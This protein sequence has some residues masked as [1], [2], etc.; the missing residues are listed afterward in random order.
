VLGKWAQALTD[1][2]VEVTMPMIS[3]RLGLCVCVCVYV[4]IRRE[5]RVIVD[6]TVEVTLY[7]MNND[8]RS[9]DRGLR[10]IDDAR[11]KH[12][13]GVANKLWG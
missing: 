4:A 10:R 13:G 9:I 11:F 3:K 8:Q 7:K 1:L 6:T 2:R 12:R 5:M